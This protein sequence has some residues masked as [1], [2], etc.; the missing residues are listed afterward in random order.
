MTAALLC[1]ML[2]LAACATG[3]AVITGQT[4]DPIAPEQVK[5]YLD[6]PAAFESIGLVSASSAAG[7]TAQGSMD[8]AIAELKKQAARLGANGVLIGSS[9]DTR[10][11]SSDGHGNV[12]PVVGKTIQ[13]R[14]IFVKSQ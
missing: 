12:Y 8:Y 3:S 9:G 10:S 11:V 1:A 14:A 7:W 13:G 6:P 5:V 4:R 2:A